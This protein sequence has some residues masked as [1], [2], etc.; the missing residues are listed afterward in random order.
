MK[1]YHI[2]YRYRG[3]DEHAG[4]DA[5]NLDVAINKLARKIKVDRAKIEVV[6]YSIIGYF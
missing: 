3:V 1:A 4:I 5:R 2:V 6:S